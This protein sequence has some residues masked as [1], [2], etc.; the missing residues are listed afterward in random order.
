[1]H[2]KWQLDFQNWEKAEQHHQNTCN[3]GNARHT[4]SEKICLSVQAEMQ[5]VL[6]KEKEIIKTPFP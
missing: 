6:K 5:S 4:V 1:M 2:C 3:E